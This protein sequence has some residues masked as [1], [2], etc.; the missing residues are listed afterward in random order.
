MYLEIVGKLCFVVCFISLK[1]PHSLRQLREQS[2]L[3]RF[4]E[5]SNVPIQSLI[6]HEAVDRRWKLLSSQVRE[7]T[8]KVIMGH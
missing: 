2:K 8:K 3:T 1:S 6:D 5:H 7:A 4:D